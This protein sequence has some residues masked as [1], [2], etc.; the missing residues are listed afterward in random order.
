MLKRALCALAY[1][2][3]LYAPAYAH[4]LQCDGNPVPEGVKLNCCGKADEHRVDP[5][6]VTRADNGDFIVVSPPYTFTVP[7]ANALPSADGCSHIFYSNSLGAAEAGGAEFRSAAD[8]SVYCF[9]TP[10]SF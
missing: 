5:A 4:D 7:E 2:A 3:L 1:T 9:L 8:P 10:M 6:N